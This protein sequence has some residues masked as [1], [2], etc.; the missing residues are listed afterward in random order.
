[1]SL[2]NTLLLSSH[3]S[4]RWKFNRRELFGEEHADTVLSY[5][6]LGIIQSELGDYT[7]AFQSHQHA[8]DVRRKLFGEEDA[9]TGG[10]YHEIGV[11]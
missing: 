10:S 4:T 2:V 1:M 8:L 7:S 9:R 11:T 6:S 3:T 5:H